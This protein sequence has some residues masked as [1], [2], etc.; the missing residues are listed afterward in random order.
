M[1]TT[2]SLSDLEYGFIEQLDTQDT[3]VLVEQF[4][5]YC[6]QHYAIDK[7]SLQA[8]REMLVLRIK[9]EHRNNR[10]VRSIDANTLSNFAQVGRHRFDDGYI[11]ELELN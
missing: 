4:K 3:H 9:D 5:N 2:Q 1:S 10:F 8:D 11:F 7:A 6:A